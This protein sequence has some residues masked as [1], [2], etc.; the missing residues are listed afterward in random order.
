MTSRMESIPASSAQIR[1]IANQ[2]FTPEQQRQQLDLLQTMNRAHNERVGGDDRIE[3]VIESY[4][5]AFRMQSA[6]PQLTNLSG[7]SK[8]TR[9]LYGIDEKQTDDFGRQCLLARR[10]AEAA[11]NPFHVEIAR[12][13]KDA[14]V[15]PPARVL[16]GVPFIQQQHLTCSPTALSSI[17]VYWR[18]AVDHVALVSIDER[19]L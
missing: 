5:L 1:H 14:P 13:L 3:G 12:R 8:A 11:K 16:L 15:P 19:S 6:V 10:F 7:E 17:T 18:R 4:E 2:R 9:A